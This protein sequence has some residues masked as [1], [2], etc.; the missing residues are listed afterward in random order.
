MFRCRFRSMGYSGVAIFDIK[1][2]QQV[3]CGE[4]FKI[5]WHRVT[6]TEGSK[7][8]I[9]LKV[10]KY[11]F[12]IIFDNISDTLYSRVMKL[13]QRIVGRLSKWCNIGWPWQKVTFFIWKLEHILHVC[14]NFFFTLSWHFFLLVIALWNLNKR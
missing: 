12:A 5:I 8:Q 2:G 14:Y 1:L 11:P 13:G 6:L 9:Y 7:S 4:T 10:R 3:A